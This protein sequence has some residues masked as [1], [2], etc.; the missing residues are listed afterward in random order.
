MSDIK[1]CPF[2]GSDEIEVSEVD[3]PSK[4]GW[5]SVECKNCGVEGTGWNVDDW[6]KRAE[7]PK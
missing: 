7:T 5:D 6:N 1:P 2:C 4:S 3:E